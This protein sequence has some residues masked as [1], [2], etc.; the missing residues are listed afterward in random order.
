MENP[1]EQRQ[2]GA[3]DYQSARTMAMMN[4]PDRLESFKSVIDNLSLQELQMIRKT[5]FEDMPDWKIKE[6]KESI[7]ERAVEPRNILGDLKTADAKE[8]K[9][10][11]IDALEK[12]ILEKT[13]E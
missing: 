8:R 12:A 2:G 4:D 6:L 1:K 10:P 3:S 9:L 5:Q 7:E 11:Y 13:P